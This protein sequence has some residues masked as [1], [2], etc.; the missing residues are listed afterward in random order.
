MNWRTRS[1]ILH[2]FQSM[3]YGVLGL[4]GTIVI[5]HVEEA[6]AIEIEHVQNQYHSMVENIV[7]AM[8]QMFPHVTKL[9]VLVRCYWYDSLKAVYIRLKERKDVLIYKHFRSH[10]CVAY[11]WRLFFLSFF[12]G[13]GGLYILCIFFYQKKQKHRQ[14]QNDIH[15]NQSTINGRSIINQINQMYLHYLCLLVHVNNDCLTC[16]KF[17]IYFC[18]R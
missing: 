15:S 7:V 9:H 13:G 16:G 8:I 12:W 6:V 2:T 17:L 11:F 1:Y 10:Y 3:E 4:H 14:V 5:L 18:L